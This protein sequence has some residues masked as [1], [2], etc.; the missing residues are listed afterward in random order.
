MLKNS[1]LYLTILT[2]LFMTMLLA[3]PAFAQSVTVEVEAEPEGKAAVGQTVTL[4]ASVDG[5]PEGTDLEYRFAYRKAGAGNKIYPQSVQTSPV[6]SKTIPASAVGKWDLGVQVRQAGTTG[7]SSP[8]VHNIIYNYEVTEKE[9]D[10]DPLEVVSVEAITVTV[11]LGTAFADIPFTKVEVTLDDDSTMRVEADWDEDSSVP[12]YEKDTARDYEVEGELDLP[13]HVTN[14]DNVKAKATVTV[15]SPQEITEIQQPVDLTVPFA[16]RYADLDLPGQVNAKAGGKWY[17]VDVEWPADADKAGYDRIKTDAAQT[18]EGKLVLPDYLLNPDKEKPK[19]K[20]T[21]SE[22]ETFNPHAVVGTLGTLVEH[23]NRRT[24][25]IQLANDITVT[26]GQLRIMTE[27]LELDLD[28]NTIWIEDPASIAFEADNITVLN[29]TFDIPKNDDGEHDEDHPITVLSP[30]EFRDWG[31]RGVMV[32]G[33]SNVF[34]DVTFNNYFRDWY[35]V[36][37]SP[38]TN[39]TMTDCTFNLPSLFVSDVELNG[40]EINAAV[41]VSHDDAVLNDPVL[42]ENPVH[43]FSINMDVLRWDDDDEEAQ[44]WDVRNG[45]NWIELT[46]DERPTYVNGV[47]QNTNMVISEAGFLDAGWTGYAQGMLYITGDIAINNPHWNQGFVGIYVGKDA[48]YYGETSKTE[49]VIDGGKVTSSK[50]KQPWIAVQNEKAKIEWTGTVD[51][52]SDLSGLVMV[53]TGLITGDAVFTGDDV[54][55]GWQTIDFVYDKG[56]TWTELSALYN[57][58]NTAGQTDFSRITSL[59][60][61]LVIVDELLGSDN[62]QELDIL[63]TDQRIKA[64]PAYVDYQVACKDTCRL[65]VVGITFDSDAYV[66][67]NS[68]K[69]E[70]RSSVNNPAIA[71]DVTYISGGY[72]YEW[73]EKLVGRPLGDNTPP[74]YVQPADADYPHLT[75]GASAYSNGYAPYFGGNAD[76]APWRTSGNTPGFSYYRWGG[77]MLGNVEFGDIYMWGNFTIVDRKTVEFEQMKLECGK[78]RTIFTAITGTSFG[79]VPPECCEKDRGEPGDKKDWRYPSDIQG[80]LIGGVIITDTKPFNYLIFGD[81]LLV[82][83]VTISPLVYWTEV[84]SATLRNVNILSGEAAEFP[85]SGVYVSPYSDATFENVMWSE[86]TKVLVDNFATL[87]LAGTITNQGWLWFAEYAVI[88]FATGVSVANDVRAGNDVFIRQVGGRAY[89]DVDIDEYSDHWYFYNWKLDIEV[90]IDNPVSTKY[91]LKMLHDP[92]TFGIGREGVYNPEAVPAV[93]ATTTWFIDY[94]DPDPW[95]PHDMLVNGAWLRDILGAGQSYAYGYEQELPLPL[96]TEVGWV[97]EEALAWQPGQGFVKIPYPDEGEPATGTNILEYPNQLRYRLSLA[98]DREIRITVR[99]SAINCCTKEQFD[100]GTEARTVDLQGK[101]DC[102][103]Y[104]AAIAA[105]QGDP[106]NWQFYFPWL[107]GW[108][109]VADGVVPYLGYIVMPT[110]PRVDRPI[111]PP[112]PIPQLEWRWDGQAPWA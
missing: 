103:E 31:Y 61:M 85:G 58:N 63:D 44:I 93:N 84:R 45:D 13:A 16:T 72:E 22:E 91:K 15:L 38:A 48:K 74:D 92:E 55:L 60:E 49:V 94:T 57:V 111:E 78:K 39:L 104:A 11:N 83:D 54:Y 32:D 1:K 14:P 110:D 40:A 4:T 64:P 34:E 107:Q 3:V 100:F 24:P 89:I 47:L 75:P 68:L 76:D 108:T 18:I 52:S 97:D 79:T 42:G 82:E 19:I 88:D 35:Q 71:G 112:L 53:G 109:Y 81:G 67:D 99:V 26:I 30:Y 21:V 7:W 17:K 6:W 69:L 46:D 29:G 36:Q 96:L 105:L 33:D 10:P 56:W 37:A 5:V 8:K 28:G 51:I 23:L 98:E 86:D 90:S 20:V 41:S 25:N 43:E 70:D 2:V 50:Y 9:E 12:R 87:N 59:E 65:T 102:D 80:T 95:G 106:G 77:V 66:F 101:F 62:D 73:V 27:G